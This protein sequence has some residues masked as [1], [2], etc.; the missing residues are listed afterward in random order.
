MTTSNKNSSNIFS[1]SNAFSWTILV[2]LLFTFALTSCIKEE[3]TPDTEPVTEELLYPDPV[4]DLVAYLDPLGMVLFVD[5]AFM[6]D[7]LASLKAEQLE[8]G[9]YYMN[10]VNTNSGFEEVLFNVVF[11]PVGEIYN[12]AEQTDTKLQSPNLVNEFT[13]GSTSYR[14]YKNAECGAAQPG[15][16]SICENNADGTSTHRQWLPIRRCKA[17]SGFCTEANLIAGYQYTYEMANCQGPKKS[18]TNL[19]MYQCW[20]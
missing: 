11:A 12:I 1:F 17:G 8:D 14:V 5:P 2:S 19:Y 6:E 15:F 7:A 18:T 3:I 9:I 20:Q 10:G 16:T 4:E 13:V